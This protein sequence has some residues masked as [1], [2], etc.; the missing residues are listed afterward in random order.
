[1]YDQQNNE[2]KKHANKVTEK[3]VMTAEDTLPALKF[4]VAVE[5]LE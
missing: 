1:M 2:I 3:V 5:W 4:P